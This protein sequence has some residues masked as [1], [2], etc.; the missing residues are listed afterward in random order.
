[1]YRI[2]AFFLTIVAVTAPLW[3]AG[4]PPETAKSKPAATQTTQPSPRAD[5]KQFVLDV[6]RSA[7][8]LPQPDPQDRLRVLSTAASVAGTVAPQMAKSF[9]REGARIEVELIASGET[10]AV[11]L[12]DSGQVDCPTAKTFVESV[13]ASAVE[14]AEQSI[15]GALSVCPKEALEPVRQKVETA[16]NQGQLAARAILALIEATG[17]SSRWSQ[18]AFVKMFSSLPGDAEKLASE[19]PNYGAMYVRMAGE[20][21]KDAAKEAGLKLL[22]WLAKVP[23]GGNKNIAV[24]MTTDAMKKALGDEGYQEALRG[25]VVAQGV[26]QTAGRPG[27]IDHPKDEQVSVLEAIDNAGKDR[28]DAL[29]SLPAS[30]RAREAAADGFANGTSGNRKLAEHYFDIAFSALDEVWSKRSPQKNAADVIEEVSEA[31]AQVDPIKALT[32][33]QKLQDPSAQA[34]GMLAVARVVLG[35]QQ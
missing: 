20:V 22:D 7:V 18:S 2:P 24:N 27:E 33:T 17:P 4:A 34:I 29:N 32:R 10:P 15:I 35:Q 28:S 3:A 30:R 6:V 21:E 25:D 23:D 26:A 11:S 19:A 9:A 31:A 12:M 13:P 5:R 1:M 16:L 14:R 8:A